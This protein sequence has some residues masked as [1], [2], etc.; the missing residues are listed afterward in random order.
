MN[1]Y[2]RIMKTAL[3]SGERSYSRMMK[4]AKQADSEL[5]RN[6]GISS[7]CDQVVKKVH[8]ELQKEVERLKAEI[9]EL[10]KEQ[11]AMRAHLQKWHKVY[12]DLQNREID[13]E[14]ALTRL[15]SLYFSNP[16]KK[17]ISDE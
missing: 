4:I 15:E 7:L 6:K 12:F 14:V 8:S 13:E 17:D 3:D 1:N 5:A 2:E 9:A 10:K 11:S 16:Y